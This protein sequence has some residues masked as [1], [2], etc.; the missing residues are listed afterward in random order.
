MSMPKQ[1]PGA[2]KQDYGTPE[3]FID[4]AQRKLGDGFVWDLAANDSNAVAVGYFD[5]KANSLIQDWNAI[6]GWD[7]PCWLWLNPPFANIRPWVKKCWEESQKGAKVACLVPASVGANWW[8]EYVDGKAHVLFL[9]GRLTFKGETTPYP[10]DCALLL[11]NHTYVG[12]YE[13]WNWR[14]E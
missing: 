12:G 10:K 3:A 11:Y 4:A 1:K 5:E 6:Q 9:Q 13:V 7:G 2:S 14:V 8:A